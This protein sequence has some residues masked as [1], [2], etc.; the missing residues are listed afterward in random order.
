MCASA[1]LSSRPR[2]SSS[3][4]LPAATITSP[5]VQKLGLP[6]SDRWQSEVGTIQYRALGY[7]D[8]KYTVILMGDD[9]STAR[10][11]GVVDDNWKPDPLG[12]A[13]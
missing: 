13:A 4:I 1:R 12:G 8:R 2:T 10:Y 11:I 5:V 6:A 9:R 3:S 7:P